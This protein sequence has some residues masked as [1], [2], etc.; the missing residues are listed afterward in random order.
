[1]PGYRRVPKRAKRQSADSRKDAVFLNVPY[2]QQFT[3]LFLAY[4]AGISAFGL[5]PRTT[6]EIP[7]G[8]RRLERIVHMIR[9]CG[10]SI[11][12][13]SRVELSPG[14]H[15]TPRFNMPFELG[16]A[17]ALENANR[18]KHTWFAFESVERR[19]QRSLSDLD[20]TDVYI[21]DG[22]VEGVF[23]ELAKAFVRTR[24]QPTVVQMRTIYKKVRKTLPQ[25][26][27]DA[28]AKNPF[29]ARVFQDISVY[30]SA[31]ADELTT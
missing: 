14:P 2:D 20:G 7:G 25:F 22:Q 23:R 11:H 16:L 30:A 13:L 19:I 26:L 21:H 3:D 5:V 9:L 24:Q 29:Q 15:G 4:V 12:D 8:T 6:L 18:S 27:T 31:L 28:G 10:Y 17:V 1:M